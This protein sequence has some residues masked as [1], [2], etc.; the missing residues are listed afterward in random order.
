L[1]RLYPSQK[2]L[3]P[4]WWCECYSKLVWCESRE[5]YSGSCWNLWCIL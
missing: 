4:P 2:T 5:T 1:K 3:C